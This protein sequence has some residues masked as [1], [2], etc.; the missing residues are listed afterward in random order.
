MICAQQSFGLKIFD[1]NWDPSESSRSAGIVSNLCL[2]ELVQRYKCDLLMS[3]EEDHNC[4]NMAENYDLSL[5][6]IWS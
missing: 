1:H 6:Y 4:Q 5:I 2:Q 3:I